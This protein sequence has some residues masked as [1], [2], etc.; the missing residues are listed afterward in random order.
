V[1][2]NITSAATIATD[3]IALAYDFETNTATYTFPGLPG[4]VLP[5][6]N[7]TATLLAD[8]VIDS[9]DKFA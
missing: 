6:G 7:Y 3:D 9:A 1:I 5:D 4:G 8:Q 2:R